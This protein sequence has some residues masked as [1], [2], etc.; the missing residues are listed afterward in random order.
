MTLVAGKIQSGERRSGAVIREEGIRE[1][2]RADRIGLIVASALVVLL[3]AG[4][5]FLLVKRNETLAAERPADA[6]V[7]LTQLEDTSTPEAAPATTTPAKQAKPVVPTQA[8]GLR[9]RVRHQGRRAAGRP[10][11]LRWD[12]PSC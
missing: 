5:A 1:V 8:E 4:G 9:L 12:P 2:Q 10:S 11:T 3:V 7:K 6:S